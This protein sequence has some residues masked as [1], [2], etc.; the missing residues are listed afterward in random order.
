M[1]SNETKIQSA[2]IDYL[3]L[4]KHF[5]TRINNIPVYDQR[6]KVYRAM[7]KGCM[8]GVP[9]ILVMWRGFPVW[10]EV[11]DKGRQSKEQKEFQARCEEQGIEYWVVKSIDDVKNIGL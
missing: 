8:K 1:K 6:R 2:I 10:L 11:K 7:P 5:F 3:T 4:K 9:D